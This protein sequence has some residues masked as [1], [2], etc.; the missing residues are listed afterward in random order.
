MVE[1]S[2]QVSPTN[3]SKAQAAFKGFGLSQD[4]FATQLGM[5]RKTV[6][7]FLNGKPIDRT[8]FVQICD[9]LK[10]DWQSVAVIGEVIEPAIHPDQID[11]L[12]S[13][14]R[15]AIAPMIRQ[16]CGT[17]RVLDMEQAIELTG[18][19]GIYT[20]VNI[21]ERL[22]GRRRLEI[23]ELLQA[24]DA[25]NF[26]RAGLTPITEERVP[27]LE[28]VKR[29]DRLLALGKPGAGKSTFLKW[30]A[31]Q[32]IEGLEFGDR[33]PFFITLKEFAETKEEPDL[34]T[35]LHQQIN[36]C[37]SA[38]GQ[39]HGELWAQMQT[40][41]LVASPL[42]TILSKGK[43]LLLL[44]GLDEVREEDTNRV[45]RQI[46]EFSEQ[47]HRNQ[48]VMTCRIAAKDYTFE[49][50]REVEVTDFEP[51]QIATFVQKWFRPTDAT[52]AEKFLE[53]LEENKPIQELASS[54]LLLTLL[55]LIFG[56]ASDF[57][58]NRSELYK[59]GLDVLLKKWDGKR[60]IERQ[61]VY[62]NLSIQRK[63]DLLSFIALT[64]FEQKD[65][66]FKQKAVE[67]QI[68]DFL[69]D[70]HKQ[71]PDPEVLRLDSEA[72]LK[73]IEAHHG[74]LIE[75]AKGIYSFS[76]LTFHEYFTAREIVAH[77]DYEQLI[78][79]ITE[80]YWREV[81]LLTVGM[82]RKA[83]VLVQ[84][85]KKKIDGLINRDPRTREF[86]T[87]VVK[88]PLEPPFNPVETPYKHAAVRA[89]YFALANN[90][91]HDFAYDLDL[92][93]ARDHDR[94][95]AYKL[96]NHT[97]RNRTFAHA[98]VHDLHDIAFTRNCDFTHTRDLARDLV[99]DLD[100]AHTHDLAYAHNPAP[101]PD[102]ESKLQALKAQLPDLVE[103]NYE[104]VQQWWQGNG[105]QWREELRVLMIE[106][107]NIGHDWQF[108]DEQKQLLRQYYDANKLLVDCLN[109]DCSV[110][111]DV[112]QEIEAT[113]LLPMAETNNG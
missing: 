95:F 78:E 21:L 111:P 42:S 96:T 101:N 5:T 4:K 26:E 25:E 72:V 10:L 60:S 30:L 1:R 71:I 79:H 70:L 3:I 28:A 68:A 63:E 12:V 75:R 66:F 9:K 94:T 108:N 56:E 113:L 107:R 54:P 33:V 2:L 44:D 92:D 57:P 110:S 11:A 109:S 13:Q 74:L 41:E 93:L 69:R 97:F 88:K 47:F 49:Q 104:D 48:Y 58:S 59:E 46:R 23:A 16:R 91:T 34:L 35:H 87:W 85:M 24:C 64:T 67:A 8:L 37:L 112:R 53:K 38:S 31:M 98:L 86:L 14:M 6:S 100:F 27:G 99:R 80:P 103:E 15:M 84:L 40:T 81:F 20:N 83:D 29:Y 50:F 102:L 18:E 65:Y 51:E 7:N 55:C 89:F 36:K 73:S 90:L 45:L 82:M 77:A 106:H 19:D 52:K 61:Q 32:S 105:Q 62:K 43:G 17:M 22:T 76:H 39:V